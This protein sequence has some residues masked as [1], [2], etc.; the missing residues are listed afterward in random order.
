MEASRLHV[1]PSPGTL[2]AKHATT[3]IP[4]VMAAIGDPVAASPWDLLRTYRVCVED[5]THLRAE[6]SLARAF[7]ILSSGQNESSC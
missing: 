5:D 7:S 3:T 2:A 1:C 6:T 4:I